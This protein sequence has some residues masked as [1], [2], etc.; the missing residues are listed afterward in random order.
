MSAWTKCR[1]CGTELNDPKDDDDRGFCKL[2]LDS[3]ETYLS[4]TPK[5]TNID[6]EEIV[7]AL[8]MLSMTYYDDPGGYVPTV[9]EVLELITNKIKEAEL[10][11][12]IDE[13]VSLAKKEVLVDVVLA[14]EPFE[15]EFHAV[16]LTTLNNRYTQLT[17][18]YKGVNDE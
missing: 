10:R 14:D 17:N 7:D 12:R 11:G 16:P 1:E 13:L 5:I 6:D 18:Q 8:A 4:P 15:S 2:H 3:P 9:H